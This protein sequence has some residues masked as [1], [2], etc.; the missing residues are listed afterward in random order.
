MQVEVETLVRVLEALRVGEQVRDD[1]PVDEQA[2]EVLPTRRAQ[3]EVEHRLGRAVRVDDAAARVEDDDRGCQQVEPAV[4]R[5]PHVARLG[6]AA[7]FAG[8]HA[9]WTLP[10]SE[11]IEAMSLSARAMSSLRRSRR[12]R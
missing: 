6:R 7:P 1:G 12:S 9:Y 11:R 5:I 3:R 2:R 10:I 8:A 4:A